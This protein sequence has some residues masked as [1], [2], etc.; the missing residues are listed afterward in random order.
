M[1]DKHRKILL[2]LS[3]EDIKK[4][5]K[6]R[7]WLGLGFRNVTIS[8]LVNRYLNVEKKIKISDEIEFTKYT[9]EQ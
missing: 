1:K 6:I 2:S 3:T 7:D 5:E 9:K 8:F 4:I